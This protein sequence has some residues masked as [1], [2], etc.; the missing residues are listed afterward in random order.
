MKVNEFIAEEIE[1]HRKNLDPSDPRDYIDCYLNEIQAVSR[2]RCGVTLLA[3]SVLLLG[4]SPFGFVI[5][6]LVWLLPNFVMLCPDLCAI[7]DLALF[8]KYKLKSHVLGSKH[9]CA[10][11]S[12]ETAQKLRLLLLCVK[13]IV[14]FPRP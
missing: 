14:F 6:P 8:F 12:I 10:K 9:N 11:D 2:S 3:V 7:T 5:K 4:P 1:E 13:K